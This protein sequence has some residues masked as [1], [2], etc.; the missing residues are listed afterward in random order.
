M[1][2]NIINIFNYLRISE[3]M[4]NKNNRVKCCHLIKVSVFS[5]SQLN[6]YCIFTK[7]QTMLVCKNTYLCNLRLKLSVVRLFLLQI[8]ENDLTQII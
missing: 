6:N 8:I 4:V 1:F 3:F 5:F 7:S 2:N